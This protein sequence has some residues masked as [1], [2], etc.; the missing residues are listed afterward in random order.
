MS[1]IQ[2]DQSPGVYPVQQRIHAGD[3]T[4]KIQLLKSDHIV[5]ITTGAKVPEGLYCTSFMLTLLVT[6]VFVFLYDNVTVI[7]KS[8]SWLLVL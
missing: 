3:S 7:C 5:Y 2:G 1:L 8:H 6:K 4:D